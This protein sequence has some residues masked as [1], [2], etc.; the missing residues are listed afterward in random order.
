MLFLWA[1]VG[2]ADTKNGTE[3][4]SNE[5]LCLPLETTNTVTL[6]GHVGDL[7]TDREGLPTGVEA[8]GVSGAEV[9]SCVND[10]RVVSD[11]Q[12]D[13]V[14]EVPDQEFIAF[15][16]SKEGY[17][18]ARWVASPWVD[19][20]QP[21][22]GESYANTIMTP[23]FA[24]TVFDE[25]GVPWDANKTLV[26]V[27]VVNPDHEN[28]EGGWDLLGAIVEVTSPFGISLVM[29]DDTRMLEEGNAL[30]YHSDVII[31]NVDTGPLEVVVTPPDDSVCHYP[32]YLYAKAGELLHVSI[33]C[34]YE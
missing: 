24:T 20:L 1:I 14:M 11:E 17:M 26:V 30:S 29:D 16:V 18:P 9:W 13:F 28:P 8:V 3:N 23:E 33:Y 12:G 34:Y 27:D 32:E 4:P 10:Q 22:M 19:G 2:C 31:V 5:D 15:H 7:N 6:Y 21:V 25:V